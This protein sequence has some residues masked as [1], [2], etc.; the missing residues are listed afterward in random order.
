LKRARKSRQFTCGGNNSNDGEFLIKK[1]YRGQK[2]A[3]LHDSNIERK[4][5]SMQNLYLVK[6][7]S[8]MIKKSRNL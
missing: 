2:Q 7:P 4:E 1:N 8:R 5:I 3:A 6:I